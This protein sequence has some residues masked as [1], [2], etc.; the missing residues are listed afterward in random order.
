MSGVSITE[1]GVKFD[2]PA[3]PAAELFPLMS[4]TEF[5][6][7][8]EDIREHGQREP[9]VYTPGG[10]VLD[11]RNR[12]R[13]CDIIGIRPMTRVEPSEPWAYV[14]S[15]NMRRRHL[16]D[17][18]RQMIGARIAERSPGGSSKIVLNPPDGGMRMIND[19]SPSQDEAARLLN[20][21]ERGITRARAVIKH[22]TRSLQKAVDDNKLPVTTASRVAEMPPAQQEEIVERINAGEKPRYVVPGD[23]QRSGSASERRPQPIDPA[24]RAHTT[25]SRSNVLSQAGLDS[26]LATLSGLTTGLRDVQTVDPNITPEDAV[27]YAREI[28]KSLSSQRNLIK[29]LEEYANAQAA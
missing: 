24:K 28:R 14:I 26:L 18:Q 29:L 13:A 10:L 2:P 12:F 22:G 23:P 3:H 21:S 6:E 5:D 19:G 7:L 16:T 8:V 9:I 1:A 25:Y 27:S 15:T 11:G 4:G 17:N 20:V